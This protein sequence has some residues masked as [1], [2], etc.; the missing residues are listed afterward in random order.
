MSGLVV[1]VVC[2]GNSLGAK[3]VPFWDDRPLFVEDAA[4]HFN[5]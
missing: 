5:N 1:L 3:M 4:S 2:T